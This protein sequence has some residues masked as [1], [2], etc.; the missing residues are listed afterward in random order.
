MFQY[1]T[2]EAGATARMQFDWAIVVNQLDKPLG[3][4]SIEN[5]QSPGM[6]I[7]LGISSR[8]IGVAVPAD[9]RA[10]RMVLVD[11]VGA[12]VEERTIELGPGQRKVVKW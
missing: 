10:L 3:R 2:V 1:T 5:A 6:M 4:I 12:R 9:R 11:D 8:E 7:D